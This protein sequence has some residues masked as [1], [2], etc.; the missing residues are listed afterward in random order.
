MASPSAEVSVV[1]AAGCSWT[2]A[3][4][5]ISCVVT[6]VESDASVVASTTSNN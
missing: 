6:V 2:T 4:V 3:S 1:V 5:G